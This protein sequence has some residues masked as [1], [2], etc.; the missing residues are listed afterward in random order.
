MAYGMIWRSEIREIGCNLGAFCTPSLQPK[1]MTGGI[2]WNERHQYMA[3]AAASRRQG[4]Q[5]L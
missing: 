5:L 3:E 4:S 2:A 1:L